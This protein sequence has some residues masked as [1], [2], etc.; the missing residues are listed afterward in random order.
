MEVVAFA[1]PVVIVPAIENVIRST[2]MILARL[3]KIHASSL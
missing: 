2:A 1:V 3:I